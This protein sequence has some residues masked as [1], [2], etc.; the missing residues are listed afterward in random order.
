MAFSLNKIQLIGN[1]GQDAEHSTLP[2]NVEVSKYT[3]A[4]THSYKNKDGQWTDETTWHNIVSFNTS[5]FIKSKL[6]KGRKVYI[7]GRL[8]KRDYQDK[9]GIK[10][11]FVEVVSEKII[12]LDTNDSDTNSDSSGNA[13]TYSRTPIENDTENN[14]DLPF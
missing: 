1:L 3:L 5:D 2:S 14:T 8:T 4:T 9:E 6:K 12:P 7:E 13:P 10:R 11:Y